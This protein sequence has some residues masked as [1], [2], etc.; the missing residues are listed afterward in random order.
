MLFSSW[1]GMP[2]TSQ[3]TRCRPPPRR[4]MRRSSCDFSGASADTREGQNSNQSPLITFSSQ[5]E[6]L[7][8]RS[9]KRLTPYSHGLHVAGTGETPLRLSDRH[10]KFHQSFLP[11]RSKPGKTASK[12][13]FWI[14]VTT[15]SQVLAFGFSTGPARSAF[16]ATSPRGVF[17]KTSDAAL[18][19][20]S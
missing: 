14:R 11:D 10:R 17:F 20:F 18:I 8:V 2:H 9:W 12:N 19:I 15:I 6:R 4:T 1:C 3:P 5:S 7:R 16:V 13:A